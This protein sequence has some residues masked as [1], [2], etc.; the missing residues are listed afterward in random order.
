MARW[1]LF[2]VKA[3]PLLPSSL[4]ATSTRRQGPLAW[5]AVERRGRTGRPKVWEG[6]EVPVGRS[7]GATG[8]VGGAGRV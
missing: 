6:V 3:C 4:R 7:I 1:T 2:G 8:L 5:N